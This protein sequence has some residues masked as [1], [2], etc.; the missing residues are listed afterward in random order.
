M[1]LLIMIETIRTPFLDTLFGLVTRIGEET[2][3]IVL[4][5]LIFWCIDKKLGYTI[6]VSYFVSALLVQGLKITFRIDRPWILDPAFNPVESAKAAA[7]GYSFPSGHTQ[8]AAALFGT[9]GLKHKKWPLKILVFFVVVLVGFSRMYLGVHTLLDVAT[10]IAVSLLIA[11]I[12]IKI[13]AKDDVS[14]RRELTMLGILVAF[15][16][17]LLVIALSLYSGATIAEEYAVDSCK[18]AGAGLG[19]AVG[20]YVER[21]Y[22][23]FDTKCK[24]LWMQPVKFA[25]GFA[26]V[27]L[28]KEGLKLVWGTGLAVDILRYFIVIFWIVALFPLIIK[29]WLTGRQK[30]N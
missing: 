24:K 21:M 9:I 20:M 23:R 26:G 19:F 13:L 14:K 16:G 15:G 22:I 10:S 4:M 28:F 8:S 29:K 12:T 27:L 1:E 25:I 7:T 18:A 30:E 2:I 6:G 5:C 11:Y 3:S 17:A